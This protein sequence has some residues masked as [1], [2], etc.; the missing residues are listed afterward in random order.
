MFMNYSC[1]RFM[2]SQIYFILHVTFNGSLGRTQIKWEFIR[3]F[4]YIHNTLVLFFLHFRSQFF[5]WYFMNTEYQKFFKLQ[6]K[7]TSFRIDIIKNKLVL[8]IQFWSEFSYLLFFFSS[9]N[10]HPVQDIYTIGFWKLIN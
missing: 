10:L 6:I 5:D 9:Q 2:L 8:M 3:L 4:F 7:T 1:V